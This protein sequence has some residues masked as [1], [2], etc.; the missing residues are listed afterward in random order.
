MGFILPCWG[1]ALGFE[2]IEQNAMMYMQSATALDAVLEENNYLVEDR[3][4]ATDIIVGYTI[5]WFVAE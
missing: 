3:F 1:R 4:M 5:H 2:Y